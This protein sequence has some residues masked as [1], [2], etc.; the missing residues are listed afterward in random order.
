MT[1]PYEL[2]PEHPP[3]EKKPNN[4]LTLGQVNG[5]IDIEIEAILNW[6]PSPWGFTRDDFIE[7][8]EQMK[9]KTEK[10]CHN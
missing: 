9:E 10:K 2:H 8:L 6:S 4:Y 1:D 5:I 3:A 7:V